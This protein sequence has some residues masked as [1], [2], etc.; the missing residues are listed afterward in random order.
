MNLAS[1]NRVLAVLFIAIL[2]SSIANTLLIVHFNGV[3]QQQR[4]R[5]VSDL[6]QAINQTNTS[7][8]QTNA[9]LNQTNIALNQTYTSLI[10]ADQ[11]I[12]DLL[13]GKIDNLSAR[14]PIEEYDYVLY[15]EWGYQQNASVYF[16]KNG[17]NG[18]VEYN[19]T[20][21]A[22]VF[23]RAFT[24][25]NSVFVKSDEYNFTG[26][27]ELVNQKNARLDSD[28]ATL[29][30]NGNIVVIRGETFDYSRYNQISGF[31]IVNG[32]LRVQNS[33]R[34]TVTNMVFNRC[35]VGLE[36]WNTHT[37]TEC[38]RIDTVHFDKCVQGLVFRTNSSLSFAA[39]GNTTGSYANTEI[40]RCYFNQLDNSIAIHVEPYAELTDSLMQDIRVWIAEFG[41]FN[42][43]GLQLDGSMYKTQMH[44]VVF[45]SF[46]S[47]PLTNCSLY[48]IKLGESSYQS[49]LF[50]SGV[51]ILGN[52]NARV[53]N[54]DSRW[55]LG[56]GGVFAEKDIAVPIGLGSYGRAQIIQ[57]HPA[58]I[59][60]FKPKI[61]VEGSFAGNETITVRFRIEFLD[62]VVSS[63]VEKAFNSTGSVWLTDDDFLQLYSRPNLIFAILVDAKASIPFTDAAVTVDVYG[64]TT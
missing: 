20:N 12:E 64:T 41:K 63:S 4:D 6:T 35:P 22:S 17:R 37:W 55:I 8:D 30:L 62:H 28:G 13:N 27:V 32:T 9:A 51:N 18:T 50:D 54:P 59:A 24:N 48:A 40:C 3:I 7:V 53:F 45:E 14:L 33:F 61:S 31:K 2:A 36:L 47:P 15:R 42:Q 58:T 29:N 56:T 46:A 19:S 5:D 23:N 39:Q 25:G 26:S 10:Q 11:D 60:G 38:T 16:L 34:T 21:A 43:T 57:V 1:S 52:W 44:G 49:P